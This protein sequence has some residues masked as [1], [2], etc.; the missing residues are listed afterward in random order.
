MSK[1]KTLKEL[2]F[3]RIHAKAYE[4]YE[5]KQAAIKR[6]KR[7]D[8]SSSFFMSKERSWRTEFMEFFNL[9]EEELK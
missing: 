4:E 8:S 2:K 7:N 5:L 9:T 6:L 3:A 1:L